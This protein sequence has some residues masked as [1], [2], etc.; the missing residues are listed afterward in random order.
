MLLTVIAALLS[1][2]PLLAMEFADVMLGSF[3]SAG[4]V[5]SQQL[6]LLTTQP[7]HA[8]SQP[9]STPNRSDACLAQADAS[10]AQ[11]AI[12]ALNASQDS[13]WTTPHLFVLRLVAMGK[14]SLCPVM[15]G[16]TITVMDVQ[17]I[18]R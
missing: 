15:M 9:I 14:D 11:I 7:L 3:K 12:L 17:L 8:M 10:A 5:Y 4:S 6:H 1:P 18:V 13:I 2:T 16:I